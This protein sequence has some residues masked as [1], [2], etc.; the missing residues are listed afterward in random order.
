MTNTLTV[1]RGAAILLA[2]ITSVP[3]AH[4]ESAPAFDV[5]IENCGRTVHFSE[6]PERAVTV[7]QGFTEIMLR[8]GL[9]DRIVGTSLWLGPLPEDLEAE[10]ANLSR[11]SD[12]SPAFEAVLKV[13]P[14]LVLTEWSDD[15]NDDGGRVGSVAQF[16]DFGIE[17]YTAALE[18]AKVTPTSGDGDGARD[19]PWSVDLLEQDIADLARIFDVREAGEALIAVNRG[20][21]EAAAA[22]AATLQAKDVSVLYWFSSPA[23][24][25]GEAYVAGQLGAPGWISNVVGVR[26][27]IVSNDEWPLVGWETIAALDPTVIVL[28]TMDRRRQPA[29]DVEVRRH[30]L[31]T[32]PVA[33]QLTAV[34]EGHLI[35]MDAQSMNPTLRSVDGVETLAEGLRARGLTE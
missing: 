3:L 17:V 25:E 34:R 4:A 24:V 1:A 29:D 33:S 22:D 7:G 35:E 10:A 20:R 11:L 2:F 8:L 28:A 21:I 18:C 26:N 9:K 15:I 19:R 30:F 31:M 5:E 12:N 32:D 23:D 13:R 14:Q 16:R 27:V 6:P